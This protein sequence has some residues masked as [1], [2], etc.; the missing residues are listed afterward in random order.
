MQNWG[1]S[2][3][4]IVL[5][6]VVEQCAKGIAITQPLREQNCARATKDTL[7]SVSVRASRTGTDL[8][9]GIP[10]TLLRIMGIMVGMNE[11]RR[12]GNTC[13]VTIDED[14]AGR[15]GTVILSSHLIPD[16]CRRK[17][18]TRVMK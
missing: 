6:I 8:H 12:A 18:S 5:L 1:A 10:D 16:E 9:C 2:T 7:H 15:T 14:R 4:C 13:T 11:E 3:W 17:A